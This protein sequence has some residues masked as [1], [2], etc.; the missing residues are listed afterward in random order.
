[1]FLIYKVSSQ[2]PLADCIGQNSYNWD[3]LNDYNYIVIDTLIDDNIWQIGK[4][5]KKLFNSAYSQPFAIITDTI[6]NYPINNDSYFYFK[7]V[8][9]YVDAYSIWI[10]H[11]YDTDSLIDGGT[12]ELSFDNCMT[13]HNIFD[14]KSFCHSCIN[15][16]YGDYDSIKVN[17]SLGFTGNSGN[18]NTFYY[19]FDLKIMDYYSDTIYLR[20]GFHSDSIETNKE[21]WII[22]DID[23][24]GTTYYNI[25]TTKTEYLNFLYP[26]PFHNNVNIDLDKNI[27]NSNIQLFDIKGNLLYNGFLTN[28]NKNLI[29]DKLRQ[30]ESGLY[31]IK[32]LLNNKLYSQKII[33]L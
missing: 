18:W 22:D 6:N 28:S 27:S 29:I 16:Y 9:N 32:L 7:F 13:W 19:Y 14:F 15:Y 23:I 10:K 21:G 26:N 5:S 31:I 2:E 30:L 3:E 24:Q 1:M 33:K 17:R 12:I 8:R 4:P 25:E 11:R 20:F